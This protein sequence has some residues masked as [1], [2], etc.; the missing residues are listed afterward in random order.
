MPNA[1][2]EKST[3]EVTREWILGGRF[4]QENYND[5]SEKHPFTGMGIIG[6]DKNKQALYFYLARHH[7]H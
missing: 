6:Y 2:E 5:N 1:P 4:L 7:E 3:A